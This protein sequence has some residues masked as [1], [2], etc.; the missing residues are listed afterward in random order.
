[1][2][3]T[4]QRRVAPFVLLQVASMTSIISGSMMF[5]I[6]PW[7][8]ID[9]TKQ[10][11]SAGLMITLSNIPGLLLSPVIG[12]IIDK[13]GRRRIGFLSE[14]LAAVLSLIFP[15]VAFSMG[16]SFALIVGVAFIRSIVGSGNATARKA[17]VPDTALVAK[18]TLERAN[19]I[20]ES[21]FAAGFAIGPAVAAITI[22]TIGAVE[23]FWI[24]GVLGLIAAFAT[25]LIKVVEQHEEHDPDEDRKFYSYA[26]QGFKVLFTTPTVLLLMSAIMSLALIYLPTEMVL[27][28]AYY[29]SLG[30]SKTLG[31]LISIMASFTTIGSL[32]FERLVKVFTFSTL[33]KFA[34]FG[35]AI[36]MLP[37]SL[38]PPS[39]V[40]FICGAVLGLAWGPLPPLLNTVIQRQVPANKRGRVF[41][42]EMT[43]WTAGP[44]ISMTL[45]GMAVDA[46]G[47]AVI[48]P[49]L[50]ISV[51]IA[52]I[53]V[54]T[55]KT[56]SAL[57]DTESQA[58]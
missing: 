20:H 37:M 19:S 57:N 26:V 9:L 47:V 15:F 12:S 30:D 49:A 28:P 11:T 6:L 16:P 55:R 51:L 39:W 40:M 8:A 33:F 42:L 24:A 18:I 45:A 1:M 46:W 29:N 53:F 58:N 35:V 23:S 25:L 14:F 50:A 27:L 38:L 2:T 13:F 48:Y 10:A 5:L 41:S 21:V 43:I 44:M 56:V 31:F 3:P 22:Q 4:T 34:M 52:A 17:L 36:A 54:S 32:L 7:L